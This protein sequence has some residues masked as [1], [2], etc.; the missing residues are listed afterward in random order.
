MTAFPCCTCP[1]P[2]GYDAEVDDPLPKYR[3]KCGCP[4][5]TLTCVS[6]Q[7]NARL[8]GFSEF[9]GYASVP[10]KK[11][12][13][14]EYTGECRAD[15][16]SVRYKGEF[17]GAYV[18]NADCDVTQNS[19]D[20]DGLRSSTGSQIAQCS[21]DASFFGRNFQLRTYPL[22]ATTQKLR[23]AFFFDAWRDIS[24]LWETAGAVKCSDTGLQTLS[25]EDT[26]ADALARA[27]ETAGTDC[28]S[29]Y[30][31]R[32]TLFS[33]TVR[34]VKFSLEL[35]NLCYGRAYEGCVRIRKRKAFSGTVPDG[36]VVEWEDIEPFTFGPI[37]PS[38][39][40]TTDGVTTTAEITDQDLV[41]GTEDARGWEYEI[42]SA[43]VWP[44]SV[45]CDC[46][47]ELGYTDPE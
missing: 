15:F 8:C 33:L 27:E 37:T 17:T 24:Y 4:S 30:E 26:E 35:T 12:R 5:A 16:P 9:S 18:L 2:P 45:G 44:V 31:L 11:Y 36:E 14:S 6:A 1:E 28:F 42:V 40:N 13:T 39:A 46:P 34:T 32:T 21:A 22:S 3:N 7:K 41:G 23:V 47:T 10:P 19:R 25:D 20:I 29:R 43:H 38:A